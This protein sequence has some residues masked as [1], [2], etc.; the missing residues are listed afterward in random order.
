M[1]MYRIE[2]KNLETNVTI[3]EYGFARYLMRR[4]LFLINTDIPHTF[5][6]L[7]QITGIDRVYG[8]K[9]FI[10]CIKNTTIVK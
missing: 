10:K 3:W 1:R 8:K 4:L 2:Y 9:V 5:Y 6:P 7:Y